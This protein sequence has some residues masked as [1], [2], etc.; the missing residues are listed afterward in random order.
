MSVSIQELK[1]AFSFNKQADLAT[2]L[3]GTSMFTMLQRNQDIAVVNPVNED[4]SDFLGGKENEFPTQ[5]FP[6]SQEVSKAF[7]AMLTSRNAALICGFGMG[8]CSKA[9]AGTGFKYTCKPLA[10]VTDGIELPAMSVAEFLRSAAVVDRLLVGV[11]VSSFGISFKNGPGLDNSS[12]TAQFVGSGKVTDPSGITFPA[13]TVESRLSAGQITAISFNGMNYFDDKTFDSLDITW[14]NAL[15]TDGFFPGSGSQNGYQLRGRMEHGKRVLGIR[16]VARFMEGSTEL[17]SVLAQ[18]EGTGSV[19]CTGAAFTGGNHMLEITVH[20]ATFS[21]AV[22]TNNAGV[23][24]V[25]V[26]VRA[27][28]DPIDGNITIEVTCTDDEIMEAA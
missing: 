22:L 1:T 24:T 16:Y 8:D 27:L 25:Q 20:R 18:S 14:D 7:E 17:A 11:V 13:T 6:T 15:R 28:W 9:A 5:V 10:P 2:G 3:T 23:V 12:M 26:D 21:S 4:D 19:I